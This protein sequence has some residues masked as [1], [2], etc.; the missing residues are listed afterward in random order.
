MRHH[1]LL[2]P[3]DSHVVCLHILVMLQWFFNGPQLFFTEEIPLWDVDLLSTNPHCLKGRSVNELPAGYESPVSKAVISLVY[4][5]RCVFA[6]GKDGKTFGAR[7][8]LSPMRFALPEEEMF[9]LQHRGS[10]D[11]C[12]PSQ[13]SAEHRAALAEV[14][15]SLETLF[16]FVKFHAGVSKEELAVGNVI[17]FEDLVLALINS[18]RILRQSSY[19]MIRRV[20]S[21][22][23]KIWSPLYGDT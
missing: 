21:L 2:G 15:K 23:S 10:G 1:L 3:H 11:G 9:I 7:G 6:H 4:G 16:E 22:L 14:L 5:A 13:A 12:D 18:M 20:V 19:H 8:V 17:P